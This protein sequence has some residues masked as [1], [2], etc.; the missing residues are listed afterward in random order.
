MT[1][2]RVTGSVLE[3]EAATAQFGQLTHRFARWHLAPELRGAVPGRVGLA[4]G[5]CLS[6]RK[7]MRRSYAVR[8][9]LEPAWTQG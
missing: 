3:L 2:V 8:Q 7:L 9:A 1:V 4:Q 5:C 6:E